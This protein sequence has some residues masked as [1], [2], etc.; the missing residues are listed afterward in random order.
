MDMQRNECYNSEPSRHKS[1]K[2]NKQTID[3]NK[4]KI[5]SHELKKS[6]RPLIIAGNG[7]YLS[8]TVSIFREFVKKINI[9]AVVSLPANGVLTKDDENFMGMVGH[10]GEFYANL[11]LFH[12]DLLIVLGSR[13]DVRQTGSEIESFRGNKKIIRVDIQENELAHGRIETDI[14]IN[15]DLKTFFETSMK[16]LSKIESSNWKEIINNWKIKYNSTQFYK[17]DSLNVLNIVKYISKITKKFKVN[18]TTGVGT[19][20]QLVARYFDFD[21]P[22]RKWQ[23]SSGHG[24]MGYDLP[25]IFGALHENSEQIGICFVGDGSLLMNIQELASI[26]EHNLPVIVVLLNNN[27]LG[28]VS[29]FQLMN[30]EDDLSTGNKKNPNFSKIA[31]AF[32]FNTINICNY[33][34]L[35][36]LTPKTIIPDNLPLFINCKIDS[37]EDVLPMLLGGQNL[38]E[39]YPFNELVNL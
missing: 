27:R 36:N 1:L 39:M 7:I 26:K 24:T 29:Q 22:S 6:L 8:D 17:K 37:H 34:E 16:R 38:N 25:S 2:T 10:T 19:H 23:T 3:I 5:I 20:Q 12:C 21:Y 4:I 30:W 33:N 15:T 31:E 18:V 35:L 9:P 28:I 13:L 32:G 11:A 14:N